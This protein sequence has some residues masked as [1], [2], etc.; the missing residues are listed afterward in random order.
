MT[1]LTTKSKTIRRVLILGHTG[2]I[3]AHLISC[4]ERHSPDIQLIGKSYPPFDLTQYRDA[5]E[6][7]DICDEHTVLIMLSAIKRQ[8]A[9]DI[10]SF[11]R[12]LMMVVNLCKMLQQRPVGRV[13]F[14]SSAAVY[15][16]DIHNTGIT[17]DT[18]ICPTSYY[19]MAKFTSERLLWKTFSSSAQGSLLVLRPPTVY[20]P[21][22]QGN[23]YGPAGFVKA[24]IDNGP[25]T[26]WGDGE[27]LRDFVFVEDLTSIV[28]CLT[29]HE[30]EGVLNVASGT[31]CSFRE[32][33]DITSRLVPYDLDIRSRPRTKRKVDNV[34]LNDKLRSVL[35]NVRFTGMREGIARMIDAD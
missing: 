9:D 11:V 28:H 34:F 31:S 1:D 3:G 29:F 25:I 15:G 23:T 14:L 20:G 35:P 21:G 19:G 8:F 10:E 27:E 13:I 32:M 4:F 24:A 2:F 7:A 22:D 12:N 5:S 18:P 30:Y 16:E 17:E 26:L 6:L 33:L